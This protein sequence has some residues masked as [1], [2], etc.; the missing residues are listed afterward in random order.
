M[1]RCEPRV[2]RSCP[3]ASEA[4][5]TAVGLSS[6]MDFDEWLGV[7][8]A[9]GKKSRSLPNRV[10]EALKK[11]WEDDVLEEDDVPVETMDDAQLELDL[12]VVQRAYIDGTRLLSA[13]RFV[14][15]ERQNSRSGSAPASRTRPPSCCIGRRPR[16]S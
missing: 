12:K 16:C 11:A 1:P 15:D 4:L 9:V 5:G 7:E 13:E 3:C 6:G 14:T 2:A 10:Q 8:V